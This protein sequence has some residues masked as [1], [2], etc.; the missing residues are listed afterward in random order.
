M[1]P[2]L[3]FLI[4]TFNGEHHIKKTVDSVLNQVRVL[5]NADYEIVICVNG[6]ED[7]TKS[8]L[9]IYDAVK[10]IKIVYFE[11]NLGYDA[12]IIRAIYETKGS[13]IWFLGDDDVL[14]P[15]SVSTLFQVINDN[16]HI[17]ALI[18]EPEFF[19][20]NKDLIGLDHSP[21][22]ELFTDN[23]KFI[24]SAGWN[25][26]ALSSLIV[27]RPMNPHLFDEK[28]LHGSNWIHLFLLYSHVLSPNPNRDIK[29]AFISKGTVAVRVLNPRW[30]INFGNYVVSGTQHLDV[31]RKIFEKDAPNI[32][33]IFLNL[34]CKTNWGDIKTGYRKQDCRSHWNFVKLQVSLFR[35]KPLFWVA[36]FPVLLCP[37]FLRATLIKLQ[38]YLY[39]K[40]FKA[41]KT[42]SI[43]A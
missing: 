38:E 18:L 12:N 41:F 32:Y 5:H 29:F 42:R 43:G 26:S 27:R 19:S 8:I 30:A 21:A 17:C 20:E 7:D 14:L 36:A 31:L 16:R 10:S 22:L 4:P 23:E 1:N 15:N 35:K 2:T 33:K 34:R 37:E 11:T 25:G 40:V 24:E 3:S 28:S 6:S 9:S 13:F 39:L